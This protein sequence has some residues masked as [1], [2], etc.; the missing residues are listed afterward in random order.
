M[1]HA[2]TVDPLNLPNWPTPVPP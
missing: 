1:D 2:T